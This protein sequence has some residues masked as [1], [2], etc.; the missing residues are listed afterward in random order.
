MTKAEQKAESIIRQLREYGLSY[1]EMLTV[2]RLS[3]EKLEK[4]KKIKR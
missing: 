4:L 3:L 1:G 2:I